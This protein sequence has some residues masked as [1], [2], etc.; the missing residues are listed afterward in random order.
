[1]LQPRLRQLSKFSSGFTLIEVIIVVTILS[2]L[3][4]SVMIY[5]IPTLNRGRDSRRKAD[6]RKIADALEEY[7]N[8]KGSYP[9]RSL[10]DTCGT[11]NTALT[12]YIKSVPCEVGRPTT[13]YYYLPEPDSPACDGTTANPCVRYRLMTQLWYKEDPDI[14]KLGCTTA[15]LP[16]NEKGCYRDDGTLT[17]YN[18]GVS[19]GRRVQ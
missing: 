8:D 18:Y 11:V 6:L 4:T 2:L 13:P 5:V 14:V 1:M 16:N 19:I 9:E 15:F 17:V 3:I 7:R 10:L 12:P